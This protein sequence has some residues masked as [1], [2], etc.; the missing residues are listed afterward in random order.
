M[1][2]E[3]AAL[4]FQRHQGARHAVGLHIVTRVED[5][6]VKPPRGLEGLVD[7]VSGPEKWTPS[8]IYWSV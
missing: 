4:V 2:D 8:G 5:R 6:K 3:L 7:D 1:I